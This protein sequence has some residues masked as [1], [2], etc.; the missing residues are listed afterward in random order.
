M[1][2]TSFYMILPSSTK[3]SDDIYPNNTASAFHI[4]LPKTMYLKNKYEVA[5]AEI[6]YPHTWPTFNLKQDYDLKYANRIGQIFTV[7]IPPGYYT[8]IDELI[9]E[10]N[11]VIE[12][13][14]EGV[15]DISF[16]YHPITGRV[17]LYLK[18]ACSVMFYPGLADV[19]GFKTNELYR[20][21]RMAPYTADIKRG[22]NSLY[23]YCSIC[24]PQV[25]G[26]AYVPLLRTVFITG[27]HGQMIHNTYDSPHYVQVNTDT[28]DN[29]EINIKNDLNENVSFKTGKV[30][31]KLHFRQKAL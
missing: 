3:S 23:V 9:K 27:Q 16:V 24:E 18:N 20:E 31:C 28:F 22:F 15:G 1:E 4:R 26:D 17:K 8:E 11:K 7:S 29:I 14:T 21:T 19:L 5:L 30:I 2:S 6:M 12:M 10:L 13:S 25:V